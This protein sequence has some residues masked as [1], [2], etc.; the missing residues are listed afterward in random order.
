M[1]SSGEHPRTA[2]GTDAVVIGAGIA[3]LVAA[4]K[5]ASGAGGRGV[6][7]LEAGSEPGGRAR[8]TE[9]QGYSLNFGPRALYRAT[10]RELR[11]LGVR[12]EGGEPDIA[13]ASVLREGAFHPGYAAAGPLLRTALLSRRERV[14]VARLLALCR[15][16]ARLARSD[17][18]QW[19]AA[20][21]P[22]ERARQAAFAVLRISTYVGRPEMIAADALTAHFAEV[23]RGVRY[24]DGGWGSVVDGL[25]ARARELGVELRTG[26]RA[27]AVEGGE[28]PCV[29]LADGSSVTGRSVVVAGLPPRVAAELLGRP[30][31]AA[32]SGRPLHTA[33]L[34]V[35]LTELPDPGRALV[36]GV[37]DPVY[38]SDFSRASRV[39]PPG[40]AVLHLARYDDGAG[41]APAQVRARLYGLLDRCQPGWRDVLVHERF[42]PRM[43]TMSAVPQPRFG[44]LAGRPGARVPGI[45]GVFLAGDWVGPTGLLADASVLSAVRAADAAATRL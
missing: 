4:V 2:H 15:T 28:K 26:A 13:G 23:R 21:L 25:A 31:L 41:L 29:R 1:S 14:A 35:A 44:G 30:E 10:E 33:C 16:R 45:P 40:G 8:T 27:V 6:L 24:L 34:D 20:R 5:L 32:G 43:T 17:A 42:L 11:A 38:L 36:F 7:L 19:L 3:G 12:V 18:A 37:D 9:H 22:T 39:A